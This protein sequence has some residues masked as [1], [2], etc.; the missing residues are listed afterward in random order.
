VIEFI[1]GS[2]RNYSAPGGLVEGGGRKFCLPYPYYYELSRCRGEA[3]KS[4][5]KNK[6]ER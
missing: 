2:L 1:R 5:N 3:R 4:T 6:V